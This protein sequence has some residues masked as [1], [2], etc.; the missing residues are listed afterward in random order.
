LPELRLAI[1][2]LQALNKEEEPMRSPVQI[3]AMLA[4][5][6]LASPVAA[7]SVGQIDTFSSDAEGW[8]R[9]GGPFGVPVTPLSRMDTGGPAGSGDGFLQITSTG[10]SGPGSRM[11]A[12][13]ASQWTGNFPAAG[14]T[15]IEMDLNNFGQTELTIRLLFE[16]PVGG[17]PVNMAATTV[18]RTLPPGS[19]W[20][21]VSFPIA[22]GD[23]TAIQGDATAAL[24]GATFF[25]LYHSVPIAFGSPPTGPAPIA[26]V[27]G[28]DNI[29][30]VPEPAAAA[31]M[32]AALGLLGVQA[33]TR[34][35]RNRA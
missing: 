26:A 30:A 20:M 35:R 3:A 14:V 10:A 6:L 2:R 23:L 21:H 31:S 28:I 33:W 17:P 32:L 7:V 27:L 12:N 8:F 9:G 29:T 24:T 18:G 13:N 5:A 15:A 16:D 19:G 4:A 1:R 11:V 22:P 34:R 25:R